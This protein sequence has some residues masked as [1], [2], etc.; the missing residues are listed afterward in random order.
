MQL[1]HAASGYAVLI[2]PGL[3]NLPF[4]S[5]MTLQNLQVYR[6]AAFFFISYT[7]VPTYH[8]Q[9]NIDGVSRS[10]NFSLHGISHEHTRKVFDIRPPSLPHEHA[11]SIMSF[12]NQ[13]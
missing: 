7:P 10:F 4:R 13:A 12:C 1:F 9:N 5:L 11:I 3:H 8:G 2:Q 6:H